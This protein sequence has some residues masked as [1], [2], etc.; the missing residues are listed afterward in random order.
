M[1]KHMNITVC[2]TDSVVAQKVASAL[3]NSLN[4]DKY[5]RLQIFVSLYL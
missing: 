4:F 5:S 3:L 1:N 2:Y